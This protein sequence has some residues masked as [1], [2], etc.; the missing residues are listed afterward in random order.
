[1]S[2]AENPPPRFDVIDLM[3][4]DHCAVITAN[5]CECDEDRDRADAMVLHL[6]DDVRHLVLGD[7][8]EDAHVPFSVDDCESCGDPYAGG[9]Y[10]AVILRPLA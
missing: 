10:P 9:R 5:G 8:D 4:C 2:T 3:I 7:T 6:G 1:M